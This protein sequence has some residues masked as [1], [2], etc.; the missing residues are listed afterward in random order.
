MQM[1]NDY[2]VLT[3]GTIKKLVF[4]WNLVFQ[5]V[6]ITIFRNLTQAIS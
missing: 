5:R 1:S 3:W 2:L 4:A 6:L